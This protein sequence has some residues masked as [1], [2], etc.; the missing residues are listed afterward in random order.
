M[1]STRPTTNTVLRSVTAIIK[2]NRVLQSNTMC[3]TTRRATGA[4]VYYIYLSVGTHEAT[5]TKKNSSTPAE[6]RYDDATTS[7]GTN[8]TSR[9]R[10]KPRRKRVKGKVHNCFTKVIFNAKPPFFELLLVLQTNKS[11]VCA[12]VMPFWGR[13]FLR[14]GGETLSNGLIHKRL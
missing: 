7:T 1:D 11:N 2:E 5:S 10:R 3:H 8:C 9:R 12:K 4:M 6:S 14:L 13:C